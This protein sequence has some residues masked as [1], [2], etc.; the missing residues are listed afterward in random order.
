VACFLQF[1]SSR[2]ERSDARV[3]KQSAREYRMEEERKKMLAEL[4]LND[5][6]IKPVPRPKDDDD[7][8]Y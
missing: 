3:R 6:E 1:V 2:V 7:G 4:N 5:F 8:L